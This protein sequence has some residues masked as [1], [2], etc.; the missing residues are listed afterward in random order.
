MTVEITDEDVAELEDKLVIIR[1]FSHVNGV[2]DYWVKGSLN[3]ILEHF[4]PEGH[5]VLK[6][7]K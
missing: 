7:G 5:S 3:S 6:L 2:Q 4:I 1:P